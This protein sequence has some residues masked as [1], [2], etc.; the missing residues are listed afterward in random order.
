MRTLSSAW[1]AIKDAMTPIPSV[2]PEDREHRKVEPASA[3]NESRPSHSTGPR[4]STPHVRTNP[5][6]RE[7]TAPA[8]GVETAPPTAHTPA[9]EEQDSPNRLLR[10]L[11]RKLKDLEAEWGNKEYVSKL[12]HKLSDV[13]ER[14]AELVEYVVELE[15]MVEALQAE[16]KGK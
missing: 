9:V 15:D 12:K 2:G 11:K 1:E 16:L 8:T 3:G 7:I 6:R 14:N 4:A 13:K 10:P 5:A